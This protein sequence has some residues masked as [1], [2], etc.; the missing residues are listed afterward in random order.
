[1]IDDNQII[2]CLRIKGNCKK[3]DTKKG[4][5]TETNNT[6]IRVI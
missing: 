2:F 6:I 3:L 5:E 1:M 4:T